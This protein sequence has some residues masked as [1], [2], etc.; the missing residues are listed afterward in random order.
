MKAQKVYKEYISDSDERELLLQK[1]EL[2]FPQPFIKILLLQYA[3]K[4]N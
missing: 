2:R 4:K 3:D 1:G